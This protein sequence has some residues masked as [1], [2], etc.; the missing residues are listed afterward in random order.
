MRSNLLISFPVIICFMLS[1]LNATSF[2][3]HIPLWQGDNLITSIHLFDHT[4]YVCLVS[5]MIPNL[6]L[7]D[8][9]FSVGNFPLWQGD[10]LITSIHLFDHMYILS[11]KW[12]HGCVVQRSALLV[13]YILT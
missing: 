3:N 12:N 13:I 7:T 5:K 1:F 6:F 10:N 2:V 11:Q 8:I 9:F 4:K